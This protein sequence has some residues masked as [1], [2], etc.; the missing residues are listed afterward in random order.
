[1]ARIPMVTRTIKTTTCKVLC[2]DLVNERPVFKEVTVP[3]TYSDPQKLMNA[4]SEVIDS[5]ELKPV[6]VRETTVNEQLYGMTEQQ[7][8]SHATPIIKEGKDEN[9]QE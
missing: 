2:M 8:I 7:F 5:D 6:Q 9:A 1:M 3:R 4:I